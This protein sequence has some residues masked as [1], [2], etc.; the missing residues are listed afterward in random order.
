MAKPEWGVKRSCPSCNT[1][2]YDLMQETIVC[3]ACG[4]TFDPAAAHKPR[5][6]KAA[7]AIK[8]TAAPVVEEAEAED[9]DDLVVDAEDDDDKPVADDDVLDLEADDSDTDLS[10]VAGEKTGSGGEDEDV[11]GFTNEPIIDDDDD[12]AAS[13]EDEDEE[14]G[15]SEIDGE[16]LDASLEDD[17][18]QESAG[19]GENEKR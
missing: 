14:S 1:R 8:R 18:D 16:D 15:F 10:E 12:D 2:F 4:A 7:A 17:F 6:G 13:D 9:A 19:D 5:R 3:P 11:A